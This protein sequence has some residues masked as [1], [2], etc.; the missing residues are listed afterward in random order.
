MR[1]IAMKPLRASGLSGAKR[2]G[3]RTA[4][5]MVAMLAGGSLAAVAAAGPAS[6]WMPGPAPGVTMGTAAPQASSVF[7]AYTGTDSAVYLRNE[8][9]GSVTG[10]G[11]R[12]IGGPAV[13]RAGAGA[14]LA[15]FGRG[16]DNAL[17][18]TH[19]GGSGAWSGWQSLGGVLTSGPGAA[20]GVTVG[21]GPVAAFARGT[22][23]AMWYRVQGPG[24]GW[25]AWRSLGGRLLPGTGPAAV[26]AEG[27]LVVA[28]IGTDRHIWV[29]GP[30]GMQVYGWVDFGGRTGST[31]GITNNIAPRVVPFQLV[32]LARGTDNALWY[33][34]SILPIGIQGGWTSL[35]GRLTSG[36]AA[37]TVPG[38]TSYVFVLG[39]DNLPWMRSGIWPTLGPW[40][41]A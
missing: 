31:P 16:T 33:R 20:A 3:W 1:L 19:Q 40:T 22:D 14:G 36:P 18:W 12:L 39:T 21:F 32:V 8:I 5:L 2:R 7:L 13:V 10:L 24:G 26:N 41:R 25:S 6:A 34:Q 9:T 29:F 30:M 38:G 28:V 37:A 17:W 23:G 27:N 11:G 35:G 15:V 4:G